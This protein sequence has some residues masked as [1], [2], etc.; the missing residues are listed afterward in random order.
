MVKNA[1]LK[2]WKLRAWN[3]WI[4]TEYNFP[5]SSCRRWYLKSI[6][7][8]S[9]YLLL[10]SKVRMLNKNLRNG[11]KMQIS[12]DHPFIIHW[13]NLKTWKLRASIHAPFTKPRFQT[14]FLQTSPQKASFL[15]II[16]SSKPKF[17]LFQTEINT[18]FLP[19]F[20]KSNRRIFFQ[21]MSRIFHPSSERPP[22]QSIENGR[23]LNFIFGHFSRDTSSPSPPI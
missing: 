3:R 5:I 9:F 11:C 16:N 14:F 8:R 4:Q 1:A 23:A 17:S 13:P 20:H 22:M 2:T 18:Q 10:K 12:I 7:N 19:P 21:K 15:P 6:F